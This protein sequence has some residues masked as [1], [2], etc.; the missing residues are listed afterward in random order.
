MLVAKM[1]IAGECFE[2]NERKIWPKCTHTA[3]RQ[4][5]I[6]HKTLRWLAWEKHI[7]IFDIFLYRKIFISLS[8]RRSIQSALTHSLE[9]QLKSHK[10]DREKC[11]DHL[12]VALCFYIYIFHLEIYNG[13]K[14]KVTLHNRQTPDTL[15]EFLFFSLS[16]SNNNEKLA[17]FDWLTK[18]IF[19]TGVFGMELT[20]WMAT[21]K[22]EMGVNE[23]QHLPIKSIKCERINAI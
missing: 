2:R 21:L 20:V 4:P 14:K 23:T 8:E 9:L 7:K 6:Y 15:K 5:Q 17:F 19:I 3:E 18:H 10:A 1:H 13:A 11:Q 22:I 16:K 12:D